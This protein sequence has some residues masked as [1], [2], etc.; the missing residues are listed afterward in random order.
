V[1]S[2]SIGATVVEQ[3]GPGAEHVLVN[4]ET[5]NGADRCGRIYEKVCRELEPGPIDQ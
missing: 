3:V 2:R 4:L 1:Q 5:S